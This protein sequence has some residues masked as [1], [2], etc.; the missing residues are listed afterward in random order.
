MG[1]WS[2]SA[3]APSLWL[4]S[5]FATLE[6]RFLRPESIPLPVPNAGDTIRRLTGS[7]SH[8]IGIFWQKYYSGS[9]WELDDSVHVW[10]HRY[11]QDPGV[12][13]F[14]LFNPSGLL[15]TIVSTPLGPTTMSH[16][17]SVRSTRVIEGLCVHDSCRGKGV[18]GFMIEYIDAYTSRICG[19]VTLFWARE[20]AAKPLFSTAISADTYAYTRCELCPAGMRVNP[21]EW[22]V[23]HQ[24]W[25]S[26][27]SSW[28]GKC[29]I[30]TEPVSRRDALLVLDIQNHIVVVSRTGRR[31]KPDGLTIWEVV[32]CGLRVD[33]ILIPG[34][35]T[36]S[37]LTSVAAHLKTGLLFASSSPIGGG[38]TRD[39]KA[40]NYGR[41]GVH[42]WYIYNYVPP[43]FGSCLFH[44][45]RDEI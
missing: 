35:C 18:A 24:L 45:I 20:L 6:P 23:F 10:V 26:N 13:A 17:A 21:V 5:G 29:I 41:S 7:D 27:N 16:D 43:A 9:D 25:T 34:N 33:N 4:A 28:P 44:A 1:F 39:W 14:G 36:E 31:T 19:P 38:V 11:L 37:V 22:S 15:A 32:W 8:I 42:A 40:W 3:A 30:A 2:K 12:F